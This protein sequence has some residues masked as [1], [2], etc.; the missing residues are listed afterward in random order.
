MKDRY[1]L[2]PQCA[3][4]LIAEAKGLLEQGTP[5]GFS[6]PTDPKAPQ[7]KL[8]NPRVYESLD[9]SSFSGMIV[10][11]GEIRQEPLEDVYM[12]IGKYNYTVGERARRGQSFIFRREVLA[13][14]E[15]GEKV[16]GTEIAK[17]FQQ[18]LTTLRKRFSSTY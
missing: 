10:R 3:R 9:G 14:G 5:L 11:M 15:F 13:L 16:G 12:T 7:R 8:P 2:A 1:S 6:A 4:K 18:H 17:E